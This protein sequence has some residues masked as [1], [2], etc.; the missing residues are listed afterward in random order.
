MKTSIGFPLAAALAL[1]ALPGAAA[2]AKREYG[3]YEYVVRSAEGAFADASTALEASARGR[4]FRLLATVDAGVPDRCPYKARVFVLSD[5]AYAAQVMAASRKT[6]PFAVV[7]RVTLFEDEQGLH[8]AVVNPHSVNRTVLMD[9]SRYEGFTADH[10]RSLRQ[11]VTE[12]VRGKAAQGG[13]GEMRST[14]HIGKTMGIMAGGPFVEKLEEVAVVGGG[15]WHAVARKV[16]DGLARPGSR[17]GMHLAYELELPEAETVVFGS[18]GAPMEGKSFSIVKAGRDQGRK[19]F[20]CPGLAYAGAYPIEVVVTREGDAVR[21]RLVNVMY[22]MKM[23][24]EDAGNWA[25]MTNMG[26][27]GSIQ[28]ELT[29]QIKG[30]LGRLPP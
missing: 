24:F 18:T 12:A 9:D 30:A 22:R 26:M 25:F 21:V 6:G 19:A 16:H 29:A 15:D 1:S 28:D 20:K 11:L 5:P 8:V 3:V 23:Y 7:D 13:Y 4:G 14:G 27:P 17:W 10:L 2:E